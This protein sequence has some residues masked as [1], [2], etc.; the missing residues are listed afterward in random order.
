MYAFYKKHE[1]LF[2]ALFVLLFQSAVFPYLVA[3]RYPDTDNY[4]HALRILDMLT[5]RTWAEGVYMHGNYPF[6][7]VLHFTRITDVL[8]L[9]FSAPLFFFLPIKQ[10]VFIGGFTFQ[11]G[12]AI[13]AACAIIWTLKPYFGPFLRLLAIAFFF[14]QPTISETFIFVKPDHHVVTAVFEILTMGSLIHFIFNQDKKH[15]LKLA[16][17]YAGLMLWSSIEGLLVSYAILTSLGVMALM[18]KIS[19]KDITEYLF[20]Y[21]IFSLLFLM[22]NPPY[23][24]FLSPDNGQLSFLLVVVLGFTWLAFKLASVGQEKGV[25][26][27]WLKQAVFLGLAG[28]AFIL[29]TLLIFGPNVVFAPYFP[30]FIKNVWASNVVE[31]R[32]STTS[33]V[34][35]ALIMVPPLLSI[36]FGAVS[37]KFANNDQ[38]KILLLSAFPMLFLTI[39]SLTS[40]RYARLTSPFAILPFIIAFQVWFQKTGKYEQIEKYKWKGLY[41]FALYA[42]FAAF[43]GLNYISVNNM[44][45]YNYRPSFKHLIPHLSPKEGSIAAEIFSGP[46]MIWETGKPVIAGPYHRNVEGI[47]DLAWILEGNNEEHAINLLKK[48]KVST[49]VIYIGIPGSDQLRFNFLQR[50]YITPPES[51]KDQLQT[52]LMLGR[53]L[54]C[55]ITENVNSPLPYLVFHVDFDKCG[56]SSR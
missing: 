46:E 50:L 49:I 6:G 12:M 39:F 5:T 35:F 43:L 7:E 16:G 47:A 2:I 26:M 25:L 23:A 8:W 40:L 4:T 18:S 45:T 1:Y 10:A 30:E 24:G 34:L 15:Y 3:D 52:K 36:L 54:P 21:F 17:L 42:V 14:I 13:I 51:T 29:L 20:Y 56:K 53:D 19:L 28:T 33:R 38:R 27:T 44:Y 31:L 48:H 9:L 22:I 41:L 37:F 55:G 11:A 32:P